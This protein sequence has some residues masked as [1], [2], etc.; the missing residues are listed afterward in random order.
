VVALGSNSGKA[1]GVFLH[2]ERT[3]LPLDTLND[4]NLAD[5]LPVLPE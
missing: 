5:R 1:W 4:T 3:D 2:L